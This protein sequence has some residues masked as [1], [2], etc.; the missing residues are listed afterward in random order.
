MLLLIMIMISSVFTISSNNWLSSWFGLEINMISFIPLMYSNKNSITNESLI[1]YFIIQA[2]GSSTFLFANLIN[3]FC[4]YTFQINFFSS[5]NTLLMLTPLMLKLGMTPF[6]FWFISVIE[7]LNWF[8]CYI[9]FTWQKIAPLFLI[10]YLYSST[11]LILLLSLPSL[12]LSP[13]AIF[14]QTSL[15]KIL[16][17]SSV[18]HLSWMMISLIMSK[19]MLLFYFFAYSLTLIPL[20]VIFYFNNITTLNNMIH[21][22]SNF[23][24]FSLIVSTLSLGGLPPFL[25]FLPKW[26][27]FEFLINSNSF[28]M[29]LLLILSSLMILYI[30]MH[31][32]FNFTLLHFSFL[33]WI[34]F[35]Q[36]SFFYLP[37][38]I[39]MNTMNWFSILL[40]NLF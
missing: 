2:I 23:L 36:T 32:I 29:M 8:N 31:I 15:R 6:Q 35:T 19:N 9:L 16:A 1:K 13:I 26:M 18:N 24:Y 28:V 11:N 39:F 17:Y 4:L 12:I 5:G 25:G 21:I 10:L 7:G 27:I 34:Y 38:I 30:Y 22:K 20:I 40:F 14:N 33:K 37:L 3:S